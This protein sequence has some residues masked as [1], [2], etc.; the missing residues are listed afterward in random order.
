MAA[1]TDASL[2]N[3]PGHSDKKHDAPDVQH[4]TDLKQSKIDNLKFM[5]L[6]TNLLIYKLRTNGLSLA[7]VVFWA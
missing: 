6:F 2:P 1:R 3:D 4:A 7:L 5:K